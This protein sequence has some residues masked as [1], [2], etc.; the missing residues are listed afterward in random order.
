MTTHSVKAVAKAFDVHIPGMSIACKAWGSPLN[1][2][3]LAIHGWLDNANSFDQIA[4]RLQ[5][6]FYFIAIDLPGHGH[7]AHLPVGCYYHFTDGLFTIISIMNAL[8]LKRVHLLGHSLGACLASL[9]AGIDTSRIISLSL[10]EGLGPL[11]LPEETAHE[12]LNLY[13]YNL[14]QQ[15]KRTAKGYPASH[16]AILARSIKGYVSLEIAEKLCERGLIEKEGLFYWRHDPRLTY[17]SPLRMTELQVLTCLA[18]IKAKTCLV[19][20]SNGFS[21]DDELMKQRIRA[22][23]N[24]RTEH[25][26]GGHHI[27]MEEPEA[28]AKLLAAFYHLAAQD[29]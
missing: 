1:P 29:S 19:W 13:M 17:P 6:D 23:K 15:E 11:S 14:N 26:E 12:Q 3:V 8:A 22:V 25:L 21:F 4:E 20:A 5:K 10:I 7:S 9:V 18:H 27:H 2:P 16:Q 28:V 24:I